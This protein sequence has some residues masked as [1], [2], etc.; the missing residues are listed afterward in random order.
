[1]DSGSTPRTGS[2]LFGGKYRN[3]GCAC[4][5]HDVQDQEPLSD[6]VYHFSG[7]E[8]I[9][10]GNSDALSELPLRVYQTRLVY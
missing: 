5:L 3:A 8:C 10:A 1:M 9:E 4:S 6:V 7:L 2:C